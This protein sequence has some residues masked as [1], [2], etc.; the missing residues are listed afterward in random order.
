MGIDYLGSRLVT[1]ESCNGWVVP[2]MPLEVWSG[3]KRVYTSRVAELRVR[4]D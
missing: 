2:G 3:N 1:G 4:R